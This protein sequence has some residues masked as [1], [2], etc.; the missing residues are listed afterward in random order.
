MDSHYSP[1]V[2][3]TSVIWLPAFWFLET[4]CGYEFIAFVAA[5]E[6]SIE[7]FAKKVNASDP[8]WA[9]QML[10]QYVLPKRNIFA[11]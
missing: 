8:E 6:Q 11:E 4:F 7:I 2:W 5:R 9:N 10:D 1:F 3:N